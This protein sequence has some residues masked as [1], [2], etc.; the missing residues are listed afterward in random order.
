MSVAILVGL[1]CIVVLALGF[2]AY[3]NY[4]V[5]A[6]HISQLLAKEVEITSDKLEITPETP[7]KP[8][9]QIQEIALSIDGYKPDIGNQDWTIKLNDGT[10]IE[11]KIELVDE[12]NNIHPLKVIG[13]SFK[14]EEVLVRFREV[15][16][17]SKNITYKL[18]RISSDKSFRC[19]V[20]WKDYDLK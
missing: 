19:S 2:Y 12:N 14:A 5:K 4:A 1:S 9:K 13:Q 20:Y 10:I 6:T 16:E 7:L 3:F 17:P 8:N 11:P 18:I 15:N